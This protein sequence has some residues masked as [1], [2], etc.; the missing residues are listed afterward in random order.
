M[1][2]GEARAQDAHPL[3]ADGT[4]VRYESAQSPVRVISEKIPESQ[5]KGERKI[6]DE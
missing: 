1:T 5:Q 6:L 2:A 4:S 3:P